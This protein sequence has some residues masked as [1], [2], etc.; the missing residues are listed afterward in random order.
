MSSVYILSDIVS[1]DVINAID[2]IYLHIYIYIIGVQVNI[3]AATKNVGIQC[4]LY[5]ELRASTPHIHASEDMDHDNIFDESDDINGSLCSDES[6][7]SDVSMY[8][9]S[10]DESISEVK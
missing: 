3:K 9:P 2:C 7:E 10:E 5:S 6:N 1:G 8:S 4:E